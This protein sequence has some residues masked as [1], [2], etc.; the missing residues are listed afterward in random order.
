TT[1]VLLPIPVGAGNPLYRVQSVPFVTAGTPPQA[2][3]SSANP[4][5]PMAAAP[6]IGQQILGRA[7]SRMGA[8]MQGTGKPLAGQHPLAVFLR[9]PT[10]DLQLLTHFPFCHLPCLEQLHLYSTIHIDCAVAGGFYGQE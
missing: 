5:K 6:H 10:D 4:A 2:A 8:V 1:R 9:S 3:Q 7:G